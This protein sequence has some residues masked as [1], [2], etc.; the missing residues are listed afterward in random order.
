MMDEE[1]LDAWIDQNWPY[2]ALLRDRDS[3]CR[4]NGLGAE[5]EFYEISVAALRRCMRKQ[6]NS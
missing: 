2:V 1:S 5:L 6:M 4:G 3:G